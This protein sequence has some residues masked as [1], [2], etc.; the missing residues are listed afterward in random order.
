[1]EPGLKPLVQVLVGYMLA[2]AGLFALCT[3]VIGLKATL[4]GFGILYFGCALGVLAVWW[5]EER[6]WPRAAWKKNPGPITSAPVA[7]P[8]A[9]LQEDSLPPLHGASLQEERGKQESGAEALTQAVS[10]AYPLVTRDD[11]YKIV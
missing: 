10:T 1:M 6:Q 2:I 3:A 8:S 7:G 4:W 9:L 5:Q 11:I